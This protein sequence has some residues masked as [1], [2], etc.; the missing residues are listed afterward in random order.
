MI[1]SRL[2]RAC[3]GNSRRESFTVHSTGPRS[4]RLQRFSALRRKPW[5][6][7]ALCATKVT[8]S[9]RRCTSS[10]TSSKAGCPA[11]IAL[12][13]PVS[14][15]IAS[16]IDMPGS[17]SCCQRSVTAPSRTLTIAISVMRS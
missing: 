6:K 9:R 16:G 8:P 2:W 11:T 7:R 12:V 13:M 10:A 4:V 15:W 3:C 17:S 5:S 14:D 1:A